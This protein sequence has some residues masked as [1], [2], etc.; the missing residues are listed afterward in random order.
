MSLLNTYARRFRARI[1]SASSVIYSTS[2]VRL[3]PVAGHVRHEQNWA[4]GYVSAPSA[5]VASSKTY[6]FD[7]CVAGSRQLDLI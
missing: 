6:M 5:L 2:C 7:F 1:P 4:A 3:H